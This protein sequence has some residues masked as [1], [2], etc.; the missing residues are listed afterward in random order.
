MCTCPHM[1]KSINKCY[2]WHSLIKL[3]T[4]SFLL[5]NCMCLIKIRASSVLEEKSSFK[6]L[7]LTFSSKLDWG[8]YIIYEPWLQQK[9]L[10]T[11][12]MS[13]AWSDIYN[14]RYIHWFQLL[15]PWK[16][17]FHVTSLRWSWGLSQSTQE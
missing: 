5:H 12:E 6:M 1:P 8:S 13:E 10:K 7:G 16:I 14:E 9:Q 3:L 11:I 4:K 15:E 2:R 17:S